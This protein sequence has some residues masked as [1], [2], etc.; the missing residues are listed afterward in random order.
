M[1]SAFP[2]LAKMVVYTE[3]GNCVKRHGAHP[4]LRTEARQQAEEL[5]CCPHLYQTAEIWCSPREIFP[6]WIVDE[7]SFDQ[8]WKG[9][10]RLLQ[11]KSRLQKS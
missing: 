3:T 5:N 10:S 8:L 9:N 2:S 4:N 1:D 11:M 7:H 6:A